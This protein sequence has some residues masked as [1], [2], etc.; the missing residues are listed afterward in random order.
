MRKVITV[1][2]NGNALQL[3]DDAY[4]ALGRYLERSAQALANNPDRSEIMSDLEQAIADKCARHPMPVSYAGHVI[5]VGLV[6]LV[7]LVVLYQFI[8]WPIKAAR[9]SAYWYSGNYHGPWIVAWD[10]VV[11]LVIVVAL[12]W[13][14]YHHMA[15]LRDFVNHLPRIWHEDSW[16]GT[17]ARVRL[18]LG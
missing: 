17:A 8:A 13:Y 7:G 4:A 10:G 12:T 6:G 9:H 15:Q 14:G 5:W 16:S 2:L 11:G 18:M 3:E 1:S